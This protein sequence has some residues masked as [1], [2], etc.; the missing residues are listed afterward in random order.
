MILERVTFES[1][2]TSSAIE[3]ELSE[4]RLINKSLRRKIK[5]KDVKIMYFLHNYRQLF[6][7][8]DEAS[9]QVTIGPESQITKSQK[10]RERSIKLTFAFIHLASQKTV[11]KER[12]IWCNSIPIQASIKN[13]T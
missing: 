11:K 1:E 2:D 13:I 7:Y 6:S 10:S 8:I 4:Y 9:K 12:K 3:H 5:E